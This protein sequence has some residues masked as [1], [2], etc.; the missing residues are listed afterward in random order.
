[1]SFLQ[2]DSAVPKETSSSFANDNESVQSQKG[3]RVE[4]DKRFS[5][6]SV[7]DVHPD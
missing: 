1:M 4:F 2:R 7:S 5:G 6:E 3:Y